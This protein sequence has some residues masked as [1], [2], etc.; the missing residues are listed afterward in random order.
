MG[1]E[2]GRRDM[3]TWTRRHGIKILGNSYILGSPHSVSLRIYWSTFVSF[4][5]PL[6]FYE[7]LNIYTLPLYEKIKQKTKN[8][9]PGDF[10]E[11]V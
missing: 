10:R 11:S 4:I 9:S 1:I 5:F 2:T 6:L 8:G 7:H 3:E